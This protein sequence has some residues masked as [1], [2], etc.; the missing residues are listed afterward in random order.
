LLLERLEQKQSANLHELTS[1]RREEVAFHRWLS[2]PAVTVDALRQGFRLEAE[3]QTPGQTHVLAIQDTSE[4]NYQRHAGRTR[5]L[6]TVGNGSDS[7]LFIH[8]VLAV[9]ADT[10]RCLGLVDLDIWCRTKKK[11]DNYRDL[12]IEEKESYRWVQ[13]AQTAADVLWRAGQV[14]VVCDRESDCYELLS[15]VPRRGVDVLIRAS[16]DRA[17]VNGSYLFTK[18]DSLPSSWMCR[19]TVPGDGHGRQ[20]RSAILS[21]AFT[22]VELKRPRNGGDP[23]DPPTLTVSAVVAAEIA[24]P[25]VPESERIHWRLLTSQPVT[26]VEDALRILGWYR[27]RWTIEQLFRTIKHQGFNLEDSQLETGDA[28]C[29]MAVMTTKAATRVM[30]LVQGRDGQ[31]PVPAA[32]LFSPSELVVLAYL[33]VQLEGETEK[34]KNPHPPQTLAWAAWVIARLGGWKGYRSERPPGPIIMARGLSQFEIF[35]RGFA[36]GQNSAKFP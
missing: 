26:S 7:G 25:G 30:Q 17:V 21:L 35:C 23:R 15:R 34:Q 10:G 16:R 2:N 11:A 24:A 33:L 20:K 4:I 28:L 13:G 8:P 3:Y 1:S 6:G 27:Q 22:T 36:A 32:T 12:P 5:G 9:E 18:L 19:I 14:T 31:I 29:K